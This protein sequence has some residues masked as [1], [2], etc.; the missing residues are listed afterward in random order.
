MDLTDYEKQ[1]LRAMLKDGDSEAYRRGYSAGIEAA[2][3]VI[4]NE[5]VGVD[6]A[7]WLRELAATVR[8]LKGV[9]P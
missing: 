6:D 3:E 8:E 1:Q 5:A 4:D 2:A 9:A 7:D